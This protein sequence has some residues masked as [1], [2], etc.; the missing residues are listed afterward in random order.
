M[1]GPATL[2]AVEY[3]AAIAEAMGEDE[4]QAL[5]I[6]MARLRG[7]RVYHTHDSRRSPAGWPDL[8]LARPPRLLAVE[9]KSER[10][11]VTVKQREWLEGLAACGVS[12]AVWRPSDWLGGAVD[13]ALR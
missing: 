11:R 4:L 5:V 1:S 9:L 7:W 8:I 3:H 13:A 12:V 10:G 6:G 2:R